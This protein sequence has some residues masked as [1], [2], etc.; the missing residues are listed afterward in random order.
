MGD[1]YRFSCLLQMLKLKLNS[2]KTKCMIIGDSIPNNNVIISIDG[3]P[4]ERDNKIK[5]FGV[6]IDDRLTFKD[7]CEYKAKKM[8]R[9]VNFLRRIRNRLDIKTALL[10]FN[11]LLVPH[12]DFCSS[13]LFMLNEWELHTLQLIQNRAMR[14]ISKCSRDTSIIYRVTI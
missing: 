4:I 9:K 1:L 8:S 3:Q 6:I 11:L 5:Y 14:I 7:H 2:V 10:L 13:I 12:T